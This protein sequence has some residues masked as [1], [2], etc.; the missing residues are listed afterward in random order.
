MPSTLT[1]SP[2]LTA[3]ATRASTITP[4][5][6]FLQ[7]ASMA[8]PLQAKDLHAFFGI[9]P[10]DDHL[11]RRAGQRAVDRPRTDRRRELLRSFLPGRR[12]C[13]L[14]R[15]PMT[16]PVRR[17]GPI[18]WPRSHSFP[19]ESAA[20][21]GR[22]AGDGPET[23]AGSKPAM[24]ASSS[25]S[26][27]WSHCRLSGTSRSSRSPPPC[28]MIAS[29]SASIA[30]CGLAEPELGIPAFGGAGGLTSVSDMRSNPE[31][32]QLLVPCSSPSVAFRRGDGQAWRPR[33]LE[34]RAAWH[35][36][37]R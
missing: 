36:A 5:L 15:T 1:S 35:A 11:D 33:R 16:V 32:G 12:R 34:I 30:D 2:P 17:P 21:P 6:R 10:F 7:S 20:F 27:P 4:L 26:R 18:S 19:A 23:T 9:K 3:L 22:L 31:N 13:F 14:P 24:A 25:A 28:F 29:T 37:P 8:E